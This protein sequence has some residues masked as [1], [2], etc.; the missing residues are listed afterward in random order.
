M[1]YVAW[2]RGLPRK[3]ARFV[4]FRPITKRSFDLLCALDVFYRLNKIDNF[5]FWTYSVFWAHP[6][7]QPPSEEEEKTQKT[8][9][10]VSAG[11][12]KT[13]LLYRERLWK[14]FHSHYHSLCTRRGRKSERHTPSSLP[15]P[16]PPTTL[17]HNHRWPF[18]SL[19]ALP[20]GE[21][22]HV[23]MATDDTDQTFQLACSVSRARTVRSSHL[24]AVSWWR[25][26]DFIFFG[27]LFYRQ[28]RMHRGGGGGAENL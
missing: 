3:C 12:H 14:A 7:P 4:L 1:L 25:P 24:G 8:K 9:T 16:R 2:K 26:R 18:F 15:P 22:G 17:A 10:S 6:H 19:V 21:T 20:C 27:P 23:T 28:V 11:R 5:S 13:C